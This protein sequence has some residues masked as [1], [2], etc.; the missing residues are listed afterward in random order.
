MPVT[1]MPVLEEEHF[2]VRA[3]GNDPGDI[4]GARKSLRVDSA[5][6]PA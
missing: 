1:V 6:V 5:R 4:T 2:V 3:D